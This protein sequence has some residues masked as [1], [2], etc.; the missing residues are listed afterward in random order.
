MTLHIGNVEKVPAE[1]P[2]NGFVRPF[3]RSRRNGYLKFVVRRIAQSA[4]LFF[5]TILLTFALINTAPGDMVDVMAGDSGGADP[6]YVQL[7]REKYGLDRPLPVRLYNYVDQLAHLDLGYSFPQSAPVTDLIADRVGPTLLLMVSSLA[8]AV[9]GALILGTAAAW[10][11]HRLTDG[12][13]SVLALLA[14]ATPVFWIGL[15]LILVFSV[16]LS[17]FPSS[18]METLFSGYTGLARVRDIAWHLVLPAITLSLFHLALFTRLLRASLLEVLRQDF[19]RTARAKGIGEWRVLGVHALSNALLPL[20]TMIGM[21]IGASLGG[22]VVV[23][24]VFAWPG[25][26]RLAFEA[27]NARDTNLLVGIVLFSGLVVITVNLLVDLLYGWL[28]PRIE[29][30]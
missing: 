21:Q 24:S 11:V 16:K 29:N 23:E 12:A 28:D 18:G 15:M 7:L 4:L 5:L 25:L 13:V 22:A 1:R 9:L 26:G 2:F 19:V 20:V 14:Y 27:L 17:W 30:V 6:G 3:I 8:L 10:N